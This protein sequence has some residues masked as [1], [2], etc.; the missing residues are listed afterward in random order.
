MITSP[1]SDGVRSDSLLARKL[2]NIRTQPNTLRGNMIDWYCSLAKK[3]NYRMLIFIALSIFV[4][5]HM[6]AFVYMIRYDTKVLL[7]LA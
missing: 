5:L 7:F 3:P 4:G 2:K 6:V 1:K